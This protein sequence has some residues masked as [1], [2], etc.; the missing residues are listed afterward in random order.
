MPGSSMKSVRVSLPTTVGGGTHIV[1]PAGRGP[2]S[3]RAHLVAFGPI[4]SPVLESLRVVGLSELSAD[5]ED[6]IQRS[7]RIEGDTASVELPADPLQRGLLVWRALS[8]WSRIAEDLAAIVRAVTRWQEAGRPNHVDCQ[9]GHDYLRWVPR[10]GADVRQALAAIGNPESVHRLLMLPTRNIAARFVTD[11]EAGQIESVCSR[12]TVDVSTWF[13]MAAGLVT[14]ET[15]RTFVRWK[16]RLTGTSPSKVPLWVTVAG[17]PTQAEAEEAFG[18]GFAVIDWEP[19]KA[20]ARGPELIAWVA[21]SGDYAAYLS[22]ALHGI[23]MPGTV[24]DAVLRL[25]DPQIPVVP[26]RSLQPPSEEEAAALDA[27]ARSDYRIQLQAG[28]L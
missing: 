18:Q 11:L 28:P 19:G 7:G 27:L 26:W 10:G 3:Y 8:L 5:A 24:I 1:Q 13:E 14:D 20:G 2:D 12:T 9:I 15:H 25:V 4:T 23:E 16:H 17:D 6:L 21:T 22:A